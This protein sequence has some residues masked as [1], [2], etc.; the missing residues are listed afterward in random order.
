MLELQYLLLLGGDVLV[1]PDMDLAHELKGWWD[2][3]GSSAQTQSI[4]VQVD[5]IIT[6][7]NI[8]LYLRV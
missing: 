6:N 8:N 3:E 4:T 7:R 1:N 5:K 2:N